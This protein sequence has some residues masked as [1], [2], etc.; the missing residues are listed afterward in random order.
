MPFVM[1]L[2][3][4]DHKMCVAAGKC[5]TVAK[6]LNNVPC[7]YVMSDG[8]MLIATMGVLNTSVQICLHS[9]HF[10]YI[11]ITHLPTCSTLLFVSHAHPINALSYCILQRWYSW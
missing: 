3:L 2:K 1:R 7:T 4:E 9:S 6:A 11:T 5:P 10:D 8:D